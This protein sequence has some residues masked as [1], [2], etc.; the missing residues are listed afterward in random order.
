MISDIFPFMAANAAVPLAAAILGHLPGDATITILGL[1]I[2]E[3]G[4]VKVLGYCVFLGA[5][6]PLIF[7]GTVYRM[8]EWLMTTKLVLV[9]GYFI[10]ICA[11]MVPGNIAWEVVQGF[12]RIGTVPERAETII[13][14]PHFTLTEY[15]GP[16]VYTVRGTL[17]DGQPLVTSFIVRTGENERSFAMGDSISPDLQPRY[18]RMV[19]AAMARVEQGGVLCPAPAGREDSCRRR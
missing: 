12:F 10:I 11:L 1:T 16:S 3:S 7:G 14:G 4:F 17:E 18:Q 15:D 19:A 13:L 8:I 9:L 6:V 5:F 2:S